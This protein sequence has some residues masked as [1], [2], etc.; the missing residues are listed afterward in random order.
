LPYT[1]NGVFLS[2]K[3]SVR[4]IVWSKPIASMHTQTKHLK[5]CN[6]RSTKIVP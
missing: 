2:L 6:K 5:F 1:N 3:K 4:K